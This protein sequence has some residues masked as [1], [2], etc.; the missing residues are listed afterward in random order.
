MVAGVKIDAINYATKYTTKLKA[1]FSYCEQVKFS[2]P[3]L[4]PGTPKE[5]H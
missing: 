5:Q 2:E 4:K 1:Q 3:V